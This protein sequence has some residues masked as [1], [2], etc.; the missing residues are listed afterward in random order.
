MELPNEAY[1][2]NLSLVAMGFASVSALMMLLRQMTGGQITRFDVHLIVTYISVSFA[3][4][5][6]AVAPPL[7]AHT[8]LSPAVAW[9]ISGIVAAL[10][11]FWHLVTMIRR[12]LA[13]AGAAVPPILIIDWAIFGLGG[14]LLLANGVIGN[15]GLHALALTVMLGVAMFA[16]IRRVGSALGGVVEGFD[17]RRG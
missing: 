6:G 12:R 8:G 13:V 14:L 17:P 11:T 3:I 1:L 15:S 10:L 9:G 5:G 4:T 16:F 2:L 7:M